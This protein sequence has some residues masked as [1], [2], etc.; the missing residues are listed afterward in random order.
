M[1]KDYYKI[2]GIPPNAGPGEIKKS[3]RQLAMLYHPDKH[4]DNDPSMARFMEIHEAYDT[5]MDPDK[6]EI[7]LQQRWYEQ[8]QGRQLGGSEPLTAET[9]LH[10]AVR[11]NRYA[12]Q[13][14]PYRMDRDG[15]VE[16]QLKLFSSE[17]IDIL[18]KFN[19]A[20]L[21]A[22][23][24]RL[25]LDSGKHYTLTQAAK[26]AP[27]LQQLVPEGTDS[28][29]AVEKFIAVRSQQEFWHKW[30]IPIVLLVTVAICYLIFKMAN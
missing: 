17:N 13:L 14:N 26:L 24:V 4:E 30:R 1:L 29:T 28:Y 9:I 8:S 27:L 23:I 5:L 3:F 10:E 18:K 7:Y 2:L 25:S 15:L 16:Y 19:D 11:L 21:S 20:T 6:K 22:E 12:S